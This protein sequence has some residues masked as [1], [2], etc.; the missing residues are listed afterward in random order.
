MT[1]LQQQLKLVFPTL[2]E[3]VKDLLLSP[4]LNTR[5]ESIA[6]RY[7]LNDITTGALIRITVRLLA[8]IIP[9]TQFV[10]SIIDEIDIPRERAALIAQEINRDIFNAIKEDLKQIHMVEQGTTSVSP[11]A[12]STGVVATPLAVPPSPQKPLPPVYPL[13]LQQIKDS[14]PPYISASFPDISPKPQAAASQSI[15][16]V[17]TGASAPNVFQTPSKPAPIPIPQVVPTS[18]P[19]PKTQATSAPLTQTAPQFSSSTPSTSPLSTRS[20]EV[21]P[22]QNT[23]PSTL[24]MPVAPIIPTLPI[25]KEAQPAIVSV[26]QTPPT[27]AQ[28][29]S[30]TPAPQSAL[31][32][33]QIQQI[34]PSLPQII[35]ALA[36]ASFAPQLPPQLSPEV[37]QPTPP[38]IPTMPSQYMQPSSPTAPL[39]ITVTQPAPITPAQPLSP[40][41]QKETPILAVPSIQAQPQWTPSIPPI[42]VPLTVLRPSLPSQSPAPSQE[43]QQ[44]IVSSIPMLQVTP[45]VPAANTPEERPISSNSTPFEKN[46]GLSTVTPQTQQKFPSAPPI[47]SVI[48]ST[49]AFEQKISGA[50]VVKNDVPNYSLPIAAPTSQPEAPITFQMPPPQNPAPT[51]NVSDSYREPIV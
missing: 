49:S 17:T 45:I 40:P 14:T 16:P 48:P 35:P 24:A 50:F 32:A 4:D 21:S 2:P 43:I 15:A 13:F 42:S 10:S 38:P 18:T 39:P 6:S 34:T 11:L 1:L 44:N 41:L 9:P 30:P 27:L 37:S 5:I 33:P 36:V 23:L 8:G 20:E 7:T 22:L 31:L 46:E 25:Q 29:S 51:T 3:K 28:N 47:Q 12:S 26:P 19:I